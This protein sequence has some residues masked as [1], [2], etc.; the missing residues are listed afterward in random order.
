MAS[1]ICGRRQASS[2]P[3]STARLRIGRMQVLERFGL[4]REIEPGI[5]HLSD[6]LEP[7]LRELGERSDIIKAIN[8]SLAARGDRK[9]IAVLYGLLSAAG[10]KTSAMG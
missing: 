1:S 10:V 3:I 2:A 9:K 8:R 5:W 6:R 7:T 4:A